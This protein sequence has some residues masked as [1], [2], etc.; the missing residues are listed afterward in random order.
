MKKLLTIAAAAGMLLVFSAC[1]AKPAA[2]EEPAA[3]DAA[4]AGSGQQ[5]KLVATN[6]TF[7]KKEYKVKAGEDVTFT[8]QN[9]Q[10]M[11]GVVVNG[12]NVELN[13]QKKSVTVK[14]DKPGTYDILCSVPC[15]AGHALMTAKLIVE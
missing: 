2:T 12:L 7:D 9:K 6:Y 1:G 15:G 11:H 10:G 4:A 14:P 8:L 5:V 13:N 3:S